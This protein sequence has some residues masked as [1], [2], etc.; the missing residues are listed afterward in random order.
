MV[1]LNHESQFQALQLW[2]TSKRKRKHKGERI[3]MNGR[4]K[5]LV[6]RLA[7]RLRFKTS[8]FCLRAFSLG[9]QSGAWNF[10][11]FRY[12]GVIPCGVPYMKLTKRNP[13][14]FKGRDTLGDKSLQR[15]ASCDMVY[16]CDNLCL[17]DIILS[18]QSVVQIQTGLNSWDRSQRQNERTALWQRVHTSATSRCDKI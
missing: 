5:K 11:V 1:L 13:C 15:V 7:I 17:C 6:L 16:F 12:S 2:G 9:S 4:A 18:L 3:R 14:A 10:P 8:L